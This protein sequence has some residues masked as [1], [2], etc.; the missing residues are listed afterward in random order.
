MEEAKKI[1]GEIGYPVMVKASAG[2]VLGHPE[3]PFPDE[4]EGL[5]WLPNRRR[6]SSA[7]TASTW[8]VH[9]KPRHV[10]I[11][12][13][14]DRQGNAVHLGGAGLLHAAPQPKG[15]GGMPQPSGWTNL[16]QRM[17]EA[18]VKC[19]LRWAVKGRDHRIPFWT[20]A[21]ISILWR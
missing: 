19:P 1:A 3:G 4:L 20:G 14:C 5:S 6:G 18:A 7:A 9:R 12:I 16:R 10:E 21:A 15:T 13:L 11:Q 2:A 17:G 8:K